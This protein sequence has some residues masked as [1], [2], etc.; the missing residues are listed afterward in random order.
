[1]EFILQFIREILMVVPGGFIRWMY[2]GK[3][4]K[5]FKFIHEN[6]SPYNYILSFIIIIMIAITIYIL[7]N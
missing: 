4:E 1:M 3:K 2:L 5:F 6:D 7:V